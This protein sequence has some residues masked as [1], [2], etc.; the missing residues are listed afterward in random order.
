MSYLVTNI[1]FYFPHNSNFIK[2]VK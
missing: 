2:C 1:T